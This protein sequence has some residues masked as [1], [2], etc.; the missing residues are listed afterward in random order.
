MKKIIVLLTLVLL[1]GCKLESSNNKGEV[2]A[3]IK[4]PF[5]NFADTLNEQTLKIQK[6]AQD[7]YET[8]L[9]REEKAKKEKW[10]E[11]LTRIWVRAKPTK[12]CLKLLKTDVINE[13]V[14]NCNKD[15]YV[16]V[17]NDE[18]ENFKKEQGI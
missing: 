2:K 12:E 8:A 16:E 7:D 4:D 3:T 5:T 11:T 10:N 6:K 1:I 9:K 17:R 14:I 15:R 18:V 13:E